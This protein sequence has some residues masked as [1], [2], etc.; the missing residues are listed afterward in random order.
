[1]PVDGAVP[2]E[3]ILEIVEDCQPRLALLDR[4]LCLP[5]D[6]RDLREFA[7]DHPG[8]ATGT[9]RTG[10]LDLECDLDEPADILFTTGT[11]GRRKGV[12]LTHRNIAQAAINISAF[13][14]SEPADIELVPISLGHSFGL[15]R[16]RSMAR[17]GN[18]LALEPGLTNAARIVKRLVELRATGLALV[19][20]GVELALRLT[21]DYLARAAGH[22]RYVE[23]GSAAMRRQTKETLMRLLPE[24]RLCHHFGLTEASR[25]AF[26]EYHSESDHLD[27]IGRPSPNVEMAVWD[28][29]G[30]QLPPG[31]HGELVVRGGMVM[32]E[33]WRRP[34]LTAKTLRGGWLRTGDWGYRD[35]DGY[36]HL[37]GRRKEIINVGGWKV[38][39]E[40]VERAINA[41]PGV[42]ESACVGIPD[43][44]GVTGEC[45]AAYVVSAA[46]IPQGDIVR[47][48]RER[49]EEYKIPRSW[50]RVAAIPKTSSG[51]IQRHLL[52]AQ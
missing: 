16:L 27:S 36:Y 11:T 44:Q 32:K 22:L 1:V 37:V 39:P 10:T 20:A 38:S 18:T 23:I 25:A 8:L 2:A 51:K 50:K 46:E 24:T 9:A 31:E 45:V 40:E 43:P 7:E 30:R 6:A 48:L 15:G 13:L 33:Y 47:W 35:A 21:K 19:P 3:T 49:L 29:S 52:A 42:A 4:E 41:Y 14:R 26:I 17:T 28:E 5:I 12:V 34:D